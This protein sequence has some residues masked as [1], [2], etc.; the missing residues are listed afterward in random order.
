MAGV[1]SAQSRNVHPTP[2]ALVTAVPRNAAISIDGRLDE[3]AWSA[4]T[5]ATEFT[6]SQPIEGAAATQRTEV[7]FLFDGAALY[8]G[9]RMYDSL[10]A[11][12]IK[13]AAVR[14]DQL[15]ESLSDLVIVTLD[16][17]H[18]H[19]GNVNFWINPSASIRDGAGDP[20]LDLIWESGAKIDSLG[21]TAELRIPYSQLNFSRDVDQEWGLQIVR[22]SHARNERTQLAWWPNKEN[23]GPSRYAHLKGMRITAR[24]RGME[25]MPYVVTQ[26]NYV[27]PANPL[28]PFTKNS[29]YKHRIGG[30]LKYRLTSNLTLNATF[31]P[32]FGQVEVDPA[33]VNVSVFETFFPERRPFFVE[34][35]SAFDGGN[36][37]YSRRIGRR[38]QLFPAGKFVDVPDNTAILAAAKI[39]GRTRNRFSV[40]LLDAITRR[41]NADVMVEDASGR[42]F[43]ESEAEPLSNYVVA[44]LSRDYKDGNYRFG[45][46]LTS[47]DRFTDDSLARAR[48]PQSA[49]SL[50]FDWDMRWKNRMYTF[51]GQ[52]ALSDVRGSSGSILRLQLSSARYF[53]KPD[54]QQGDNGFFSD[55][56]DPGLKQ[57][58]GYAGFTRIAKEEGTWRGEIWMNHRSPGFE[59]NDLGFLSRSDYFLYNAS[60]TRRITRPSK[61]F[62]NHAT[63]VR[64]HQQLNN[65][66]D[67]ID[68]QFYAEFYGRFANFWPFEVWV[69]RKPETYDDRLTRGGPTVRRSWTTTWFGTVGTD[70]RKPISI[71]TFSAYGYSEAE[72]VDHRYSLQITYKPA[73]NVQLSMGPAY[74]ALGSPQQFVVAAADS[75]AVAFYGR[76]YVFAELQQKQLSMNTRVNVTFTP[77]LTFEAFMQPLLASGDY[78]EFREFVAPRQSAMRNFVPGTQLITSTSSS[79]GTLYTVDADGTA[80]D[81]QRVSF[82]DPDFNFRSLRGIAVLRW[83][84]RPGSTLFFVWQQNRSS[85]APVGDFDFSRDRSALFGAHPDNIFLVKASYWFGF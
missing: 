50:G 1:V 25:I 66:G 62:R 49:R 63:V 23:G 6:Q 65:D 76:R 14:R 58:G 35:A 4:A 19:V 84:Y 77:R 64:A 11:R 15:D 29:E 38:P 30:D 27:E 20:R 45:G 85:S 72:T 67:L 2:A 24:P 47:V 3:A 22:W 16:T 78:R 61:L 71:S 28:N 55:A 42:R 68:R 37:F 36:L 59:I 82:G 21:W 46:V 31:N 60:V 7:R 10:G 13:T 40:G 43:F 53:Q 9:A 5:P 52:Y 69:V 18:D 41:E 48:L 81:A 57:L 17:Y 74:N 54:R 75:T 51:Q 56:Y 34:N 44:R 80:P 73:A 79:G 70:A 8:I 12:G 39:T 32:D 83:E 26:A 33:V